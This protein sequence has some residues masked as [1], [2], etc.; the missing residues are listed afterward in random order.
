MFSWKLS[1]KVE[2]SL[3]PVWKQ[4]LSCNHI[5]NLQSN[6][7][8]VD[9]LYGEYH[10]IANTFSWNRLNH[11]QILIKNPQYSG[12][13]YSKQM[14]WR[15]QFFDTAWKF[16]VKFYFLYGRA[17]YFCRKIKIK[18]CSTFKYFHLIHF[19][20]YTLSEWSN[21]SKFYEDNY[22]KCFSGVKFHKFREWIVCNNFCGN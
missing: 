22:V 18:F 12:D 5:F 19:S 2:R 7:S 1:T 13:F 14:L 9:I 15:T 10:L 16:Q 6:L 17:I 11:G 4:N 21:F 3:V 8:K 20:T